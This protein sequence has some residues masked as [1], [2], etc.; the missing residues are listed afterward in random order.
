[1]ALS[2]GITLYVPWAVAR[3][4]VSRTLRSILCA[5]ELPCSLPLMVFSS[6]SSVWW[7]PTHSVWWLDSYA[8]QKNAGHEDEPR[9]RLLLQM[10]LWKERVEEIRCSVQSTPALQTWILKCFF[11]LWSIHNNTSL[12]NYWNLSTWDILP[13]KCWFT[14]LQFLSFIPPCLHVEISKWVMHH[15]ANLQWR[16]HYRLDLSPTRSSCSYCLYEMSSHCYG[17][18]Q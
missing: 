18:N 9:G 14:W 2:C 3:T 16:D 10:G 15:I 8:D 13:I 12:L 17:D 6:Y 1:M 5:A 4:S 7:N 11:L